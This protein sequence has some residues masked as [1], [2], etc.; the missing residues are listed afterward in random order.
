MISLLLITS[1]LSALEGDGDLIE[2]DHVAD[3]DTP[4]QPNQ[5]L[6]P[7]DPHSPNRPPQQP[8]I[9]DGP[10]SIPPD[11]S[12]NY[13]AYA[14]DQDGDPLIYIFQWGDGNSSKVGPV[15]SGIH[16][17]A[18]HIWSLPGRYQVTVKAVDANSSS[19]WSS[20]LVVSVNSPPGQP[21]LPSGRSSALPEENASFST[22]SEDPDGDQL[23]YTFDWGD[24]SSSRSGWTESGAEMSMVHCWERAGRY[25]IRARAEDERGAS[26]PWSPYLTVEINSPPGQPSLSSDRSSALPKENASFSTSSE[27]HDGDRLRYT[28]DWA[29]GSSS[30]SGW[31][32]SGE[33]MSMVHCWKKAGRYEI[34]AR[35][36]DERGASSPWS[37]TAAIIINTLPSRPDQL[38]GPVSGYAMVPY[39]FR[40][41]AIDEDGDPLNYTFD[42]GDGTTE[43]IDLIDSGLNASLDH[44]WT[45]PG[46]YQIKAMAA[47]RMGGDW[48]E[49][50]HITIA[51][52][53]EPDSPR[54][55]YGLRSGYTGI[56][57]NF[58]TMARDPDGDKV[59]HVLDWGDGTAI[60]T[61]LVLSGSL[62]NA[63]HVWMQPGEYPVRV[64]SVDEKGAPSLWSGPFMVAI[65]ANCPPVQ[66]AVPSGPAAGQCL[67]SHGY[68]TSAIDPD[69][70]AVKYVF[71][72]GDGTTSWTGLDYL[73]SGVESSVSHKWMK[74]GVYQIKA[75]A[76]DDKGLISDWSGALMVKME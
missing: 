59:M 67:I 25:E 28:F 64:L 30:S 46:S 42:W 7:I 65:N 70:D 41:S 61:G 60:K 18:G 15:E 34:R 32:E 9:A 13:A 45:R 17:A 39:Q 50:R 75:A 27:D 63:S 48:S 49:E 38:S 66:P 37:E 74:P 58:F 62:E 29:D 53:R 23:R 19:P 20:P 51:S 71:D 55:L 26:S 40:T 12:S 47:D 69:G 14:I 11:L 10:V 4:S 44:T 16:V 21:S 43:A 68:A 5:S 72:W 57:C 8:V 22:S 52:N 2:V 3:N 76:L 36:E 56:V 73:S 24:D 31:T 54:D 33:E 35:A 6:S 1:P